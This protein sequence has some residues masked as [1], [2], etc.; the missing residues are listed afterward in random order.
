L[1][2]TKP[3]AGTTPQ[4]EGTKMRLWIF[5]DLHADR[6]PFELPSVAADAAVIAGDVSIGPD[7]MDWLEARFPTLPVIYV[8]GN[9]EYYGYTLPSLRKEFEARTKGSNIHVLENRSVSLGGVVF[10][11]CTLWTDFELYGRP[12]DPMKEAAR[13]MNDFRLIRYFE[14]ADGER[15]AAKLEPLDTHFLHKESVAWLRNEL[16]ALKGQ[17]VVVVTHHAP[18]RQSIAERYREGSLTP[19]F[20]SGL[21]GLVQDSGAELWVHGHVHDRFDYRLGKTRVV[22]NPRGYVGISD[23]NGFDP[24]LLV[25]I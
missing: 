6:D 3:I 10:L 5:S 24:A 18:S 11:G 22:C 2:V 15:Y 14:E 21:D 23:G 4:Q 16:S 12:V 1:T 13:R 9:H 7:A 20:V 17:K 8:L 19:A 25:E